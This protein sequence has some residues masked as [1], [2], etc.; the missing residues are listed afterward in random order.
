MRTAQNER[1]SRIGP[2]TACGNLMRHY[3]Q[4]VALSDEFDPALDARMAIRAVKAVRVF[5]DRKS[6]G[7]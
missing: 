6:N 5:K 3:W 1:I 7:H 4:P 2:D